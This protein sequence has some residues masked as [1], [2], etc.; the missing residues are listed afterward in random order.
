MNLPAA[1]I[2][3]WFEAHFIAEACDDGSFRVN[4]GDVPFSQSQGL[5]L[6][7]PCG[8]GA[9]NEDGS[10]RYPLDLSLNRGR[11]HGVLIPFSNPPSGIAV[12]AGFGPL[13]RDKK[14]RPRWTVSGTGLHD[15]TLS[16]SVTVGDPECW[17]GFIT[18]G[19]VK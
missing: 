5:F 13:S 15:L 4:N 19:I 8:F 1:L 2:N 16:P 17:H 6:W 3:Q 9:V 14:S 11:P 12:P 7:C 10:E 18:M